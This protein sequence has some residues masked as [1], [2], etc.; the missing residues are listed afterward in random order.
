MRVA[1]QIFGADFEHGQEY[2]VQVCLECTHSSLFNF[3]FL[4]HASCGTCNFWDVERHIRIHNTVQLL[5]RL[6]GR[7]IMLE[8]Q[9]IV[10]P[11]S[12]LG[13]YLRSSNV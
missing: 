10:Y 5:V 4:P 7:M 2:G 6:C 1:F 9:E 3:V 11:S 13:V 12:N 8:F